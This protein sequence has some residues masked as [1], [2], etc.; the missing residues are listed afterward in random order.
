[1]FFVLSGYLVGGPALV[2][3]VGGRLT[4]QLLL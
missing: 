1:V 2:R 4:L 3:C